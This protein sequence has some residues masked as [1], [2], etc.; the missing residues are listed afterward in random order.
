MNDVERILAIEA[1]KQL[2]ARYFWHLD[3]K[4]WQGWIDEVFAPDA[5]FYLPELREEPFVG[6][7]TLTAFVREA[8]GEQVTVH[9]GHT[10]IIELLSDTTATG[11]WAFE[12][13]IYRGSEPTP[14]GANQTLHG[15]GHYHETYVLLEEGWRIQTERIERLRVET[16]QVS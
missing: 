9:H 15:F 2:K 10:P 1:I 16:R 7:E 6:A 3:H 8:V 5:E 13:R 11:I 12:D 14:Q 4:N